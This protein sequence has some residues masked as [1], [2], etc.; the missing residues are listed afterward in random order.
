[1]PEK[2]SPELRDRAADRRRGAC[3]PP[4]DPGRFELLDADLR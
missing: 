3:Q 1:M 2:F 4:P